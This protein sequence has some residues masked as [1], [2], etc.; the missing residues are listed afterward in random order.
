MTSVV[1]L[2]I[3]V[4]DMVFAVDDLPTGG[5]KVL[6]S[7]LVEVGGG[8][9]ANAAVTVACLGG[10]AALLTRLGDDRV[11]DAIVEELSRLGV[12]LTDTLRAAG[13]RSPLSAVLV[14][15]SGERLVVNHADPAMP[16]ATD[17][18]PLDRLEGTDAVLV[19][20]RWP[21]GAAALLQAAGARG[22]PSVLDADRPMDLARLTAL[23]THVVFSADGLRAHAGIDDLGRALAEAAKGTRA[24]LAVT[25]GP[26][27]V[28][29]L[30]GTTVRHLPA[31]TIEAVDTLWGPAMCFTA[32]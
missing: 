32:P 27:G 22:I 18:L 30:D 3:A 23:A 26:Q 8:V 10:R 4:Q 29:W 25:D 19:D 5:G 1:C 21:D 28:F 17:W 14:D 31:F 11:G 20:P 15:R 6:A 16:E 7:D 24:F 9:A 12:D 13:H 2:G